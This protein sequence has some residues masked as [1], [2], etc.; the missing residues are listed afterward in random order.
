MFLVKDFR[1]GQNEMTLEMMIARWIVK[2]DG[3]AW[4]QRLSGEGGEVRFLLTSSSSPSF[5]GAMAKVKSQ[6]LC[7]LQKREN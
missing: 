7:V 4:S 3:A 2:I 5:P 1:K 6:K